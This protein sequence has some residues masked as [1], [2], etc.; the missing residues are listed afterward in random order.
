MCISIIICVRSSN[1]DIFVV[2]VKK[3]NYLMK[4]LTF[5]IEFCLFYT[6]RATN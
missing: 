2:Y 4:N 5:S 3:E 6:P 1:I